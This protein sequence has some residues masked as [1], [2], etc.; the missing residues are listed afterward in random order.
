MNRRMEWQNKLCC[1]PSLTGYFH[2]HHIQASR[3]YRCAHLTGQGWGQRQVHNNRKRRKSGPPKVKKL[4][5]INSVV[6]IFRPATQR[7]ISSA[8]GQR[9]KHSMSQKLERDVKC[10]VNQIKLIYLISRFQPQTAR[11]DFRHS[12]IEN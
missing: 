4:N 6:T 11:D 12:S 5:K 9:K 7:R 1:F 10:G 2:M 8:V 3:T